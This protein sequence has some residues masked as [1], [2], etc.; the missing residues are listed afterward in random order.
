MRQL[1]NELAPTV[2]VNGV[3]PSGT[4]TGLRA[5]P[6]LA[7]GAGGDD[8]FGAPRPPAGLGNNLLEVA[9]VPEDHAAAYLLLASSQSRIMTGEVI[10]TDA[11]RGVS[12]VITFR[13]G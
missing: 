10:H 13:Q 4:A 5:A 12:S 8:V 2:R 3:A 6:S 9:V 7:P 11:G 1:A